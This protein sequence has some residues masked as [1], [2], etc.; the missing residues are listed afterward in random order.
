MVLLLLLLFSLIW[1]IPALSHFQ[2]VSG[3]AQGTSYTVKYVGGRELVG[4]SQLDSIFRVIDLSLSLYEPASLINAF[5]RDGRV[6]MDEHLK[7][8]VSQA[9]ACYQESD[10][11][12][13]IT[14]GGLSELWGF[15]IKPHQVMPLPEQIRKQLSVTGS[16]YLQI[17]GDS[18]IALKKGVKIDCNGVAQGY[19]VDLIEAFMKSKGIGQLMVELGGEVSVY[20]EHPEHKVW[21]IGVE[22][23]D[24][25]AGNW[26][27]VQQVIGVQNA[28]VTTSGNYRRFYNSGGKSYSHVI[29]PKKGM[30]V[31]NGVIAVT[32]V[33]EN[34]MVAD[35]WDNALYVMGVDRAMQFL[36]TR[37]YLQVYM[38]YR[39]KDGVVKDTATLGFKKLLQ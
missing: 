4:K 6:K 21:R 26:H 24:V 35:A 25:L 19:T 29:D 8:V 1:Q 12:F 22:S 9:L 38:I 28:S 23:P 30:P 17:R 3:A 31:D 2:I 10:G 33:A 36:Q 16:S 20:G 32:V 34:A 27:P 15:G 7:K 18:L 37:N 14:T 11:S 5:N 39:D 13:D